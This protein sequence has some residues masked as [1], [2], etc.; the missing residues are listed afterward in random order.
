M[1]YNLA[2]ILPS[3]LIEGSLGSS[4][5]TEDELF[6][7]LEKNIFLLAYKKSAIAAL[8]DPLFHTMS[9]EEQKDCKATAESN[10]EGAIKDVLDKFKAILGDNFQT[11]VKKYPL[12][13]AILNDL[14]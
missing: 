2:M 13:S 5:E 7:I 6:R 12:I 3:Y 1:L 9:A 11:I 4:T 10:P 14:I 8:A